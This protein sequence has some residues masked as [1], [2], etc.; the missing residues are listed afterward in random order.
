M[1]VPAVF[2]SDDGDVD[3][4]GVGRP[5]R[6]WVSMVVVADERRRYT[7]GQFGCGARVYCVGHRYRAFP[8]GIRVYCVTTDV[9]R[10]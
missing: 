6:H 1:S 4:L 2:V 7:R 10:T 5:G 8:V 9:S 3:L